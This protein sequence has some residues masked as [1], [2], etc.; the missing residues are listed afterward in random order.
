MN[1][2]LPNRFTFQWHLTDQCNYRCIHCYQTDYSHNGFTFNQLLSYYNKI[3]EFVLHF[4]SKNNNFVSHINFTGG[5]PFLKSELLN[6]LQLV[7]SRRVFSFGILSNGFL[8]SDEKLQELKKLRPRFIQLSLEGNEKIND[9]IR[10]NGTFLQVLN[11]IKVYKKLKIPIL[12]SF[13]ANSKNY[14][15]FPDVVKIARKYK[16]SKVWTDRYLPN[17]SDDDLCLS[18]EQTKKFFSIIGATKNRNLFNRFSKTEVSSNRA[19]Q[20]L[21][22]GGQPYQCSAGK[23]LLT[24]M[25]NGDVLPCRR[26]PIKIGNLDSCDLMDVFQNNSLLQSIRNSDNTDKEC[27]NCFYKRTCNGG[28]KC[29]SFAKYGDYNR[30]DP[31]CWI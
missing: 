25:P 3:E 19:L 9:S 17:S 16:V 30:K 14:E 21:I 31:N 27:M 5:E 6:L 7:N 23:S 22:N 1:F 18:T 10:G 12:I 28:L 24:I 8:I 2:L 13:T 4:K 26:L 20:F 15:S 11:S 29:L